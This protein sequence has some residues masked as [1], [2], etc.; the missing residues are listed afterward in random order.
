[1]DILPWN[2]GLCCKSSA[3]IHPT[4]HISKKRKKRKKKRNISKKEKKKKNIEKK[5]PGAQRYFVQPRS[6]S[7]ERYHKVTTLKNKIKLIRN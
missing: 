2:K 3:K 7:G 5:I 4:D 1:M 6:N